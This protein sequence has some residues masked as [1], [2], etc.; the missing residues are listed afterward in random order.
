MSKRIVAIVDDNRGILYSFQLVLEA[1]GFK[2]MVY[3]SSSSFLDDLATRPACLIV[4]QNMP[5]MNGLELV[6][7]LRQGENWIPVMLTTGLW[8]ADMSASAAQLGIE[9]VFQKPVG[10]DDLL[11]FV[12]KYC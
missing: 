10:V 1:Y 7:T 6:A 2:V 11:N 5:G 12:G 3:S 9:S 4:D 8:S